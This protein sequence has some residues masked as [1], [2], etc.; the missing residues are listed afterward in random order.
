MWYI[1]RGAHNRLTSPH[2][3]FSLVNM[4]NN[5]DLNSQDSY[6]LHFENSSLGRE[7]N[8]E[9]DNQDM[10]GDADSAAPA[11]FATGKFTAAV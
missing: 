4:L 9:K 6:Y 8:G 7:A 5:M 3:D 10:F 11:P 2:L 1:I